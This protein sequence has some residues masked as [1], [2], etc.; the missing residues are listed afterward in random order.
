MILSTCHNNRAFPPT[1]G[2]LRLSN[3]LDPPQGVM[4][5]ALVDKGGIIL[6]DHGVQFTSWAFT[7]KIHASGL[8]R[9]NL[10]ESVMLMTVSLFL[11]TMQIELLNRKK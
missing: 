1:L 11:L 9:I 6:A 10:N 3:H 7:N 8:M 5:V 4:P 2:E